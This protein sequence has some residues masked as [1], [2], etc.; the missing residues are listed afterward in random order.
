M[1]GPIRY[2]IVAAL[3]GL[4]SLCAGGAT[5]QQRPAPSTLLPLETLWTTPLPSAPAAAPVHGADSVF[6][7]LRDG[8]IAAVNLTDGDVV[9]R[10]PNGGGKRPAVGDTLLFVATSDEL[11][12]LE[13]ATGQARW[14]IP[15]E[16][17]LSAPLVWN[18]GWLIAALD[19]HTLL[20]LRAETGETIW[21]RSMNGGIHVSPSLAGDW[22][23][24]SLDTGGIAALLLMTG[25]PAWERQ[26]EGAPSEILPLDDLFVGAAD[27]HLYRLS[28]LDGAIKWRSPTGGDVV[29]LPTVDEKRVYFSSLD[30]MLW[31]LNRTNGVRQ[32]R[33]PLTTRPTAGPGQAGD[34]L[35]LGGLSQ[36]LRFFDPIDGVPYGSITAS[37]ELAFPPTIIPTSAVGP[38]LLT[39]TGD[40][41]LRA[42]RR[43]TGPVQFDLAALTIPVSDTETDDMAVDAISDTPPAADSTPDTVPTPVDGEAA[44]APT[45]QPSLGGEYAVQIA[46]LSNAASATS[47]VERLAELGYPAYRLDPA[48]GDEPTLY[49][50]RIGDYTDRSA[51]D[52]IGRQIEAEENLEWIVVPLP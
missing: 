16:A 21:R 13:T 45:P 12:G 27:N 23:Y 11:R 39:I 42:L 17:P 5:A 28:L 31:A 30:N 3:A 34:L 51:A 37:S 6:V 52:Q 15:L 19:T 2:A 9:W 20:A 33:Q 18:H 40:G 50:V 25:D 41:Q 24:V 38:L 4:A 29:G 22:M 26:L 43:A 47:L 32:W 49:R 7:P 8:H 35:V 46:A 44:V 10:V 36:G 48:P 1:T 14:S